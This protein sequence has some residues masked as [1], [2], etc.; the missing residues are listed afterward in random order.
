[1]NV[2]FLLPVCGELLIFVTNQQFATDTR[3]QGPPSQGWKT[4]LRNHAAGIASIDL[5]VFRTI[6]FKLLYG[7]GI[8]RHA[9]R[10]VRFWIRTANLAHGSSS[11]GALK[12]DQAH[13]STVLAQ[14]VKRGPRQHI[15]RENGRWVGGDKS[16]RYII[17]VGL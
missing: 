3:R 14:W 16:V 13:K 1:M 8:L 11:N 2:H 7:L 12:E 17:K 5:F 10:R 15:P 9:R 4:F 6:S